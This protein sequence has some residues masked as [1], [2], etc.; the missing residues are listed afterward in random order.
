MLAALFR[1]R[2]PLDG[3][4]ELRRNPVQVGE[5]SIRQGLTN[6]LDRA[7]VPAGEHVW[8]VGKLDRDRQ[9]VLRPFVEIGDTHE[10]Q[11][12]RRGTGFAGSSTQAIRKEAVS[13]YGLAES[14]RLSA[15]P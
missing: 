3:G 6:A 11:S 12:L 15:N 2:R 9:S 10:G 5:A 13:P 4:A 7:W 1:S 14:R 8:D